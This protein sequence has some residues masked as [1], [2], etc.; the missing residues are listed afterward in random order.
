ML[1][2]LRVGRFR[3]PQVDSTPAANSRRQGLSQRRAAPVAAPW[4]EPCYIAFQDETS[5]LGRA[6]R[7]PLSVQRAAVTWESC[8]GMSSANAGYFWNAC[9]A[10]QKD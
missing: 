3:T 4:L 8:R 5:R 10:H 7:S 9:L 1:Q 6:S 2:T